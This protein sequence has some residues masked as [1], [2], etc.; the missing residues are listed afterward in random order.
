MTFDP[1]DP[2]GWPP[3]AME[4]PPFALLVGSRL[5]SVSVDQV[6]AE[7]VVRPELLNRNGFLHGGAILGVADN[8]GGTAAFVNLGRD[9]GTTTIESKTNFLRSIKPDECVR[10]VCTPLHRG[11]KTMVFQTNVYRGDGKLAATVMQTQIVV[12]RD[13]PAVNGHREPA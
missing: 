3:V 2:K 5:T 6:E 13:D 11:R 10:F 1:T 7:L 9:E 12:S 4:Q 8:L